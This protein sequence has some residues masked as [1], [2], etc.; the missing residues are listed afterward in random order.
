MTYAHSHT[1][2]PARLAR[3]PPCTHTK[4]GAR[5][6][7]GF[8]GALIA[9]LPSLRAFARSLCGNAAQAE[10]LVQGAC[11]NAMAHATSFAR[12]TNMRAWLFT[13][14]RNQFYSQ[15]RKRRREVEDAEGNYADCLSTPPA[16][17][18]VVDLSDVMIAL[19]SLR[20]GHR[21]VLL[22]VGQEGLSYEEAAQRSRCAV[23]T[24]KSR[25]HRARHRL[26]ELLA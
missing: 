5:R 13:I 2:E 15:L 26:A 8:D 14:L 9:L 22:L 6:T 18:H 19:A 10:D 4:V 25:T 3:P 12:G 21:E 7:A 20:D 24:I 23:G 16:Q 1:S 17:N 11:E